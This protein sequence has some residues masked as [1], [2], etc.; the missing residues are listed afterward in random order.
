MSIHQKL[1]PLVLL[2]LFALSVGA[3]TQRG[4]LRG[5]ITDPNGA[6]V[7]GA[8]VTATNIATNETRTTITNDEG[9]YTI[10]SLAA[11]TYRVEVERTGFSRLQII[12]VVLPVNQQLRRSIRSWSGSTGQRRSQVGRQLLSRLAV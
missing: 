1:L 11:A 7:P 8:T 9:W 10:S 12:D 4:S 6:V 2:I 3:Q 5:T